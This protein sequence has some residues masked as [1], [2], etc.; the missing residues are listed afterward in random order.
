MMKPGRRRQM[1]GPQHNAPQTTLWTERRIPP[2][3]A[4]DEEGRTR[5]G[6]V[7]YLSTNGT[8]QSLRSRKVKGT[9]VPSLS[10]TIECTRRDTPG[11]GECVVARSR[12][13]KRRGQEPD[14]T[15]H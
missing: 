14:T 12:G 15:N 2:M 8:H 10:Q 7:L 5:Q 4:R 1:I 9:N 6:E 3:P 13:R 11:E